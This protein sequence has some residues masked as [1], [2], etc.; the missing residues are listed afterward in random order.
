MENGQIAPS[1]VSS[2]LTQCPTPR[3]EFNVEWYPPNYVALFP[4]PVAS[5]S[6]PPLF[7]RPS[8]ILENP[9]WSHSWLARPPLRK[10]VPLP[11]YQEPIL[12]KLSEP[13]ITAQVV[14]EPENTVI[15][16]ATA[17]QHVYEPD[18][19]ATDMSPVPVLC[20]ESSNHQETEESI[21]LTINTFTT[22]M[23]RPIPP[24]VR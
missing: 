24:P 16:D 9:D 5:P 4:P 13:V 20:R 21:V 8:N 23:S 17:P 12:T 10:M 1:K 2:P 11:T 22:L 14:N 3:P 15:A 19:D 6:L 18:T 7:S